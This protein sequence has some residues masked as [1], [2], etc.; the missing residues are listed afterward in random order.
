LSVVDLAA[1][2]EIKRITIGSLPYTVVVPE[3]QKFAAVSSFGSH[4]ILRVN[5]DTLEVASTLPVG[6]SPWGLASSGNGKIMAAANF[7][8]NEISVLDTANFSEKMRVKLNTTSGPTASA[9]IAAKAKNVASNMEG[10]GIVFS[11][12]ANNTISALDVTTGKI[13]NTIKVGRAPY[14]IAFLPRKK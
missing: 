2:K 7:S 11:D 3:G 14:G 8:S 10:T 13:T 9:G 5:L 4:S 1:Q 6:R 12:L